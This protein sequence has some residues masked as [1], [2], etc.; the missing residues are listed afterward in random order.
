MPQQYI[1]HFQLA[2]FSPCGVL[3]FKWF[4]ACATQKTLVGMYNINEK[5][6]HIKIT[7]RTF[8]E[9]LNGKLWK[10]YNKSSY[11]MSKTSLRKYKRPSKNSKLYKKVKKRIHTR[12]NFV[13]VFASKFRCINPY[14]TWS[15][16]G[17]ICTSSV[18]CYATCK[19]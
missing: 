17:D 8:R 18:T 3:T 9:N 1:K 15:T 12:S 14:A 2:A 7:R 13:V 6:S 5:N 4:F 11:I 16:V 10:L 19:E